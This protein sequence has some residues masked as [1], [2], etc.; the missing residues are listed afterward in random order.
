MQR[1]SIRKNKR[2]KK[3]LVIISIIGLISLTSCGAQENC[4]GR[5][6]IHQ[7]QQHASGMLAANYMQEKN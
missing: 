6:D 1:F 4:R 7:V 3:L 2:M 5:V